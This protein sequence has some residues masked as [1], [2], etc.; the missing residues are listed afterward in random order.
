MPA[1]AC[2]VAVAGLTRRSRDSLFAVRHTRCLCIGRHE[3]RLVSCSQARHRLVTG[4]HYTGHTSHQPQH[5]QQLIARI[6]AQQ[7][8]HRVH[9]HDCAAKMGWTGS[10]ALPVVQEAGQEPKAGPP[11]PCAQPPAAARLP[12]T[13]SCP[14]HPQS[15]RQSRASQPGACRAARPAGDTPA[16]KTQGG[17]SGVEERAQ[18]KGKWIGCKAAGCM[19]R[20]WGL[21]L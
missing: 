6:P 11:R 13:H 9:P 3:A 17:H 5:R 15:R 7:A 8:R 4:I 1:A 21:C 12:S 18:R 10:R 2:A 19:H 20:G 14:L 16:G